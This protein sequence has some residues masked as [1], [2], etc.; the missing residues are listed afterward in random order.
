MT[1]LVPPIKNLL[2]GRSRRLPDRRTILSI[3][4]YLECNSDE[5]NDLLLAAGYLP[6]Q[7]E[8]EGRELIPIRFK[9]MSISAGSRVYP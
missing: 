7:P 2:V 4:E 5:R 1:R 6:I 8:L 9:Q 3:A